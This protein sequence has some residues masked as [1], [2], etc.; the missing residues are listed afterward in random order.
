[1]KKELLKMQI[2]D[3]VIVLS[4]AFLKGMEAARNKIPYQSNPYQYKCG[5]LGEQK[6]IDW[7]EGHTLQCAMIRRGL[8]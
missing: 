4:K 2:G 8:A 1:M 6:N 5:Y 7:N 3:E